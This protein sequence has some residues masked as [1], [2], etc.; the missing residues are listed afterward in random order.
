VGPAV[1]PV[2]G[3]TPT[4]DWTLVRA[5]AKLAVVALAA[6]F[7]SETCFPIAA[8]VEDAIDDRDISLMRGSGFAETIDPVWLMIG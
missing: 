2:L 7:R 5:F 3:L 4:A 8:D 1:K 6:V